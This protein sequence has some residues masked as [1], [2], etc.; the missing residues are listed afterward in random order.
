MPRNNW[1]R[2]ELI[3]TFN[4][5]LKIPFGKFHHGNKEV[6]E[7]A[8]LIHRTP[9]AVAMRL[10]NFASID[11][12]H[13]KRGIAGLRGGIAQVQPIWNEFSE[14]KEDLIFE[15]EKILAQI[16][17]TTVE[18]KYGDIL[19]DIENLEGETKIR[20]VKTRINQNV[21]RQIVLANYDGKCAVTGFN[22]ANF[23]IASH[24]I[25]WSVDKKNRLNP[26]N[27]ILLNTLHDKAFEN[28]FMAIDNEFQILICK[29]FLKS[30]DSFIQSYFS[31]FHNKKIQ[32][33][34]RFLP[35]TELLEKH[36]AEKF[37]G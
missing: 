34:V 4:L 27:G 37:L 35:D 13:Q 21:F 10:S 5:Y 16:Q 6:I 23:L 1:T 28:G 29:D 36:F 2:E 8:S 25:P 24:I 22:S 18:N 7:L 14:N 11:P 30:K 9:S 15:S 12:Y 20:A 26:Q 17:K 19:K 32:I 33:P 3:L 31:A